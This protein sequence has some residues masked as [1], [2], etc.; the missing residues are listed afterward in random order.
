[1]TTLM[2]RIRDWIPGGDKE[3]R[4]KRV[5]QADIKIQAAEDRLFSGLDL[6][7]QATITQGTANQR[8]SESKGANDRKDEGTGSGN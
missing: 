6:D 5:T 4:Q 1:M 3:E 7:I 2:E 8:D